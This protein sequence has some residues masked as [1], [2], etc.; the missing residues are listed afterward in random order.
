MR[1]FRQ[2]FTEEPSTHTAIYLPGSIE[3][4]LHTQIRKL[5]PVKNSKIAHQNS[6]QNTTK[7]NREP[8]SHRYVFISGRAAGKQNI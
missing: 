8:E 4:M 2:R 1:N 7:G 6:S 5:S 3:R